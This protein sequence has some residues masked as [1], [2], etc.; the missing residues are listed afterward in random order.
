MNK[1]KLKQEIEKLEK[2]YYIQKGRINISNILTDRITEN[3]RELFF[4]EL[5]FSE[6][7][8][9]DEVIAIFQEIKDKLEDTYDNGKLM[10]T[11]GHTAYD[12]DYAIYGFNIVHKRKETDEE[13][14]KRLKEMYDLRVKDSK[15]KK[16]LRQK[17]KQSK[18]EEAIRLLKKKG[19]KVEKVKLQTN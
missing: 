19:Y 9:L 4:S 5:I 1:Q 12:E 14:Y 8:E 13:Y 17:E 11:S 2:S 15:I 16:Q 10:L 18:E 3:L 7:I 6:G